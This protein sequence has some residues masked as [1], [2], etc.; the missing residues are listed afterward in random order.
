MWLDY[1]L[2]LKKSQQVLKEILRLQFHLDQRPALVS[3][4]EAFYAFFKDKF[5]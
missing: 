5:K 1:F 3:A 4:I 2:H